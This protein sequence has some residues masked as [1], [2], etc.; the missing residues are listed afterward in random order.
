M[1]RTW[2]HLSRSVS[3]SQNV[4]DQEILDSA[5]YVKNQDN[6]FSRNY[7]PKTISLCHRCNK[8]LL[9][10]QSMDQLFSPGHRLT[11][12]I[13]EL[14][15][16]AAGEGCAMCR[17]VYYILLFA[18]GGHYRFLIDKSLNSSSSLEFN[19]FGYTSTSNGLSFVL[20]MY[21]GQREILV[22]QAE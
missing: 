16:S 15:Y 7:E 13:R 20:E 2:I 18:K 3:I 17:L 8:M 5:G 11:P 9:S 21:E 6:T 12:T 1:S 4:I 19:F 14:C 10:T 22:A